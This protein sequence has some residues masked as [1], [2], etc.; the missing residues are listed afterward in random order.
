MKTKATAVVVCLAVVCLC[1]V[2]VVSVSDE[3]DAADTIEVSDAASLINAM[4]ASVTVSGNAVT[5]NPVNIVITDDI[6]ITDS[7]ISNYCAVYFFSGTIDGQNHTLTFNV[8]AWASL[9]YHTVGI[10]TISNLVLNST[11]SSYSLVYVSGT[12]GSYTYG[13][14][15]T[16]TLENITVSSYGTAGNNES[17]FVCMVFGTTVNLRNCVNNADYTAAGWTAVFIGGYAIGTS[18]INFY[19]CVNNGDVSGD[20]ISLFIGNSTTQSI[21]QNLTVTV[22]ENCRNNGSI[23]GTHAGLFSNIGN[24]SNFVEL[25]QKYNVERPDLVENITVTTD[26]NVTTSYGDNNI[27]QINGDEGN[28]YIVFLNGSADLTVGGTNEVRITL[29]GDDVIYAGWF[30]DK[31]TADQKYGLDVSGTYTSENFNFPYKVVILQDGQRVYIFDLS[32]SAIDLTLE[33]KP[34]VKVLVYASDGT[35]C[36]SVTVPQ[37]E[38][39]LPTP[40]TTFTGTFSQYGN[41]TYEILGDGQYIVKEGETIQFKVNVSAGYEIKAVYANGTTLT[42]SAEGIYSYTP[43]DDFTITVDTEATSYA[44]TY[45]LLNATLSNAPA[46]VEY[47]G[48][49]NATVIADNGYEISS[50]I[51][52]MGGTV[53]NV[54]GNVISI[55][56]VT[57]DLNITVNAIETVEPDEPDVPVQ[58][59]IDD[60]D[61]DYVPP[62]YVPGNTSDSSDDDTVTIVACAAAAVVA[63][64]LA[65]FLIIERRN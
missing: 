8:S 51:V 55:P 40:V 18:T 47:G 49:F 10:T 43:A 5:A 11:G 4:N 53:V 29:S 59:P 58:P 19:S 36:G 65:V 39:T 13:G 22:D 23:I 7:N 30:L 38:A 20:Y 44:V 6:T 28:T 48:S 64:I 3:A 1:F 42:P 63:A 60:D 15:T 9:I 46:T 21:V 61:D 14:E 54:T 12:S 33:C 34:T 41:V 32:S 26:L 25:N 2:S 45:N 27:L 31:T 37:F 52:T 50:I 17:A 24:N 35:Y 16:T 56:E 57:G 62:I